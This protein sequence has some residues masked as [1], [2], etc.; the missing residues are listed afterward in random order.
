V[1]AHVGGNRRRD[2]PSALCRHYSPQ[3]LTRIAM[4]PR[5][6]MLALCGF[7]RARI[8]R[9]LTRSRSRS[10][11]HLCRM[12]GALFADAIAGILH[13]TGQLEG[14]AIGWGAS[15]P[16]F[17]VHCGALGHAGW[18]PRR[19]NS[20]LCVSTCPQGAQLLRCAR[21]YVDVMPPLAAVRGIFVAV[22]A[23]RRNT[24]RVLTSSR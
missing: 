2:A 14:W 7:P 17:P 16:F 22:W 10:C 9:L 23:K 6:A 3:R 19:S 21:S 5:R 1:D 4:V 13:P 18:P 8:S 24:M 12:G 11:L 15:W 20:A